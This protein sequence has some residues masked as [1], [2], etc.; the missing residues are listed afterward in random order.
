M[1]QWSPKS[2]EGAQYIYWSI[3]PRIAY[4]LNLV[5]QVDL[6]GG[7]AITG[8]IATLEA[9]DG[10]NS[11]SLKNNQFDASVFVGLR[12]YF[13]KFLGV[14]GEYGDDNIACARLGLAFRFGR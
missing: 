13:N 7:V 9:G 10:E 12:Y 11:I 2:S 5:E 1:M 3:S 4:H 6:Y 14:Y 8:R